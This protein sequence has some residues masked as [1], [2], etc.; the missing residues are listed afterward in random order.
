MVPNHPMPSLQPTVQLGYTTDRV[1]GTPTSRYAHDDTS[2]P[3]SSSGGATPYIFRSD[4]DT[5]EAAKFSYSNQ[6]QNRGLS[7]YADSGTE[8]TWGPAGIPR[9]AGRKRG[10]RG[11]DE[12]EAVEADD[13]AMDLNAPVA[14]RL[15]RGPPRKGAFTRGG[16][17]SMPVGAF[18]FG[19][20]NPMAASTTTP[21]AAADPA[22]LLVK[23]APG[24]AAA[25]PEGVDFG[26]LFDADF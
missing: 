7:R 9:D 3:S 4:V 21:A 20:G 5:L 10:T 16:T 12:D 19:G 2:I 15:I 1:L 23:P 24:G 22:S 18:S 26:D 13:V 25:A 14:N 8:P 11:L 17:V 6:N